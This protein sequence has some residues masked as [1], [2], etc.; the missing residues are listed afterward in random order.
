MVNEKEDNF[1]PEDRTWTVVAMLHQQFCTRNDF[2]RDEIWQKLVG[3]GFAEES[4]RD[5]FKTHL[6]QQWIANIPA[7]SDNFRLMYE[8]TPGGN[9]RLFRPGDF[10]Y[11]SRKDQ[12]YK[13]SKS[14][15]IRQEIPEEYWQLL[16]WYEDWITRKW[17]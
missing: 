3:E 1:L 14:A 4:E 6:D 9:I 15:P 11:A 12:K 13:P 7:S 17:A 5:T 2:S 8:T 16:D 10:T